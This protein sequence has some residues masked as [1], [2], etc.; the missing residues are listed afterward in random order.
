MAPQPMII[1]EISGIIHLKIP[2]ENTLPNRAGS[3]VKS[4]KE[5]LV[6]IRKD[7]IIIG[8]RP[9]DIYLKEHK[10]K[11]QILNYLQDKSY[12]EYM[13]IALGWADI[14]PE[15]VVKD[16]NELLNILDELNTKFAGV[17][18]KQIFWVV[19]KTHKLRLIPE[20]TE[21]DFKKT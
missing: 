5:G 8:I 11:K 15:F 4:I 20:L 6:Y 18:K 16:F 2:R 7:R 9:V 21:K 10:K 19:E 1:A 14:E 12:I 3:S 17:I 13:N